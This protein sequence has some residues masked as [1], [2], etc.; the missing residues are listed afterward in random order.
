VPIPG[1]EFAIEVDAVIAAIGQYVESDG[2]GVETNRG[3]VIVD[4]QTLAT[5]NPGVFAGGDAVLGPASVVEAIGAGIEAAESIHRYLRHVDLREGRRLAW[6]KPQDIE[7]ET[8]SP[9]RRARR[10]HGRASTRRTCLWFPRS[11][12]GLYGEEAIAEAQR[13]LSVPYAV[14]AC[15]VSPSASGVP[16][17]TMTMFLSD[18]WT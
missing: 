14:N 17:V 4:K 18:S 7:I 11:R 2:L 1:S 15:S 12:A 8:Y 16:S 10:I 3:R 5:T 13:C 9:V 6:T